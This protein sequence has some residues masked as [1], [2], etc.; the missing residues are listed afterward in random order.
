[1]FVM[2]DQPQEVVVLLHGIGRTYRSMA[3]LEKKLNQAGY[4]VLN[5]DYPSRKKEISA[6][7][8]IVY[9]RIQP[10]CNQQY[11]RIHFVTHS[12]GGLITRV[13]LNEHEINNVAR[14]VMLGPPNQ[15]S[16]VADLLKNQRL[17]QWFYGPA[18]QQL[19]RRM[20][21]SDP[22]PAMTQEIGI[23]AGTRSLDPF[24]SFFLPDKND[25]KVTVESTR[26][27]GMKDHRVLPVT[28]VFMMHNPTVI[29]QVVHFLREGCFYGD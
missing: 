19:T 26:L 25:G 11:Y 7:A 1:M 4:Q 2:H 3:P 23:I 14:I 15:G 5:I 21:K 10:Y 29:K 8:N 13:L 16:E 27:A 18:G 22:F 24:C 9:Q 6:L 17:Y 12:M 20:A 28:H